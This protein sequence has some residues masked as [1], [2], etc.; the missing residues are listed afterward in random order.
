MKRRLLKEVFP[1][2]HEVKIMRICTMKVTDLEVVLLL[3]L[4]VQIPGL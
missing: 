1:L 2:L 3:V 4:L